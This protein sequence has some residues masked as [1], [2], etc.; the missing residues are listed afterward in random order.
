MAGSRNNI[1]NKGAIHKKFHDER[2]IVPIK[3]MPGGT[4]AARYKDDEFSIIT[5]AQG[6]PIPYKLFTSNH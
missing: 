6:R 1:A 4:I 3:M 2:E 5:D